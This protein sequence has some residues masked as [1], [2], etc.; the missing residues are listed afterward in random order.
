[1]YACMFD[2][3]FVKKYFLNIRG[4]H[5]KMSIKI[6][7]FTKMEDVSFE[8]QLNDN[9]LNLNLFEPFVS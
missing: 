4:Y 5:S 7:I 8:V 2:T 9:I 1:M 3:D 6:V